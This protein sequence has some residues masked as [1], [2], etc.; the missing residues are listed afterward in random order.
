MKNTP[1]LLLEKMVAPNEYSALQEP[2]SVKPLRSFWGA[3]VC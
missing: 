1:A 2:V 3:S